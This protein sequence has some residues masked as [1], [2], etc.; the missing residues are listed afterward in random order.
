MLKRTYGD[1]YRI[2]EGGNNPLG[3]LGCKDIIQ[4]FPDHDY[5]LCACG[6]GTTYSGLMLGKQNRQVLVGVNVLKGRNQLL[7]LVNESLFHQLHF[8]GVEVVG[9]EALEREILENSFITDQYAFSGYAGYDQVLID[10]KT[11][12]ESQY[13]VP[14]DYVYTTKLFYACFD[15]INRNKFKKGSSLLVIHSGG[16][17]GNAGFEERYFNKLMR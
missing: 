4:L 12:F 2:P 11:K 3:A 6:T 1:F 17:Q 10:F 15:L 5:L 7:N 13:Q 8:A 16:L 9:N 14:L